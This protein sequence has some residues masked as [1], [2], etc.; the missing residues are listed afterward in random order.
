MRVE[1]DMRDDTE[2]I[3]YKFIL[4]M[5]YGVYCSMYGVVVGWTS[6][7]KSKGSDYVM[8]IDV[9]DEEMQRLS[10]RIFSHTEIFAESLYVGDV[11]KIRNVKLYTQGKAI[12]G[13]RNEIDVVYRQGKQAGEFPSRSVMNLVNVFERSRRR[14]VK[15]RMISEI[16][17]G[18]RFDF[19]G[20]LSDKRREMHNLV[21][22]E[23]IDYSHGACSLDMCKH[24][25]CMVLVIKAWGEFSDRSEQCEIGSYYLIKN[26]KADEVGELAVAS[27]SE[28]SNGEIVKIRKHSPI[29]QDLE[30]RRNEYQR[31]VVFGCNGGSELQPDVPI[32]MNDENRYSINPGVYRIKAQIRRCALFTNNTISIC[33][34]CGMIEESTAEKQMRTCM[35][36]NVEQIRIARV[37]IWDGYTEIK[38]VCR[39]SIAERII[40]NEIRGIKGQVYECVI[41]NVE[42]NNRVVS[43]LISIE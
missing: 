29:W 9:V 26:L 21:I 28:S 43:H 19:C 32:H 17:C 24:M 27:L 25:S 33:K 22:L 3:E 2:D 34:S 12:M 20:E 23:F 4:Q 1:D 18:H 6:S 41:L 15:Q 38:V 31:K 39:G 8:T 5:E 14:F 11:V 16:E 36:H 13:K 37:I 30:L 40:D 35:N 42:E 7:K 10:V